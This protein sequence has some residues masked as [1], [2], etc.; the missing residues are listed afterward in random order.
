MHFGSSSF[1]ESC[2][3]W[4]GER[5]EGPKPGWGEEVQERRWRKAE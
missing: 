1:R 3:P 5:T 2:E 4:P